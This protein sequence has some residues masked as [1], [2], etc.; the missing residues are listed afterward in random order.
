MHLADVT[1]FYAPASGGVRTFLEAKARWLASHPEHRYDLLVPGARE[2]QSGYRTSLPAMTLPFGHDYRFPLRVR[3]WIRTLQSL[4]PDLIE[5]EDPYRLAWASLRAGRSLGVPV[6]GYYHSDLPRLVATRLGHW[7]TPLLERY[8]ARLYRQFDLVLAP[9]QIMVDKLHR[10]GVE[11]AEVQPLG[12]DT[13]NFHPAKRDPDLRKQLG[14]PESTFL[15]IFVGRGA[16]EK[17]TPLL[18]E[19]MRRLGAGY[20]LLLVGPGMPLRVPAN[21]TVI[22]EYVPKE[23]VARYLASADALM[24]AG[25]GETFG[26]VILEAMASGIPVIG[27]RAG[28]L[29]ELVQPGCGLLAQPGSALSLADNVRALFANGYR[30][31]GRL[32]RRRTERYHSWDH[33]FG[34]LIDR[35]HRV[36]YAA[37]ESRRGRTGHG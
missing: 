16:R 21:V 30:G 10:L 12:V 25:D 9:S 31:M 18:L 20:H 34:Q 28:A 13:R 15:L 5:A 4:K 2:E 27:V 35:Y 14:L 7:A 32:A 33:V 8:V 23:K 11:G 36:A 24:H 37:R 3:P 29:S 22:N 26:L 1:M 6:V 19:C 17:N